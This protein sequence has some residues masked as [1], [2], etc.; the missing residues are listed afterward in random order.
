MINMADE[1]VL[2]DDVQYTR[3]DWR[4]RNKI[5]T[6][7]GL[8]W[9]SIPVEVKGRFDIPIADVTVADQ[10]WGIAHWKTLAHAY[11]KAPAF[12]EVRQWLEP[13]YRTMP[14]RLSEI[15]RTFIEGINAYLGIT[16]PIH[17]STDFITPADKSTRLLSICKS[18]KA[19]SYL[20]GPAARAY[21]DVELFT[22][23]GIAVEWMDYSGYP[24]YPQLYPPFAHD[25][26]ILDLIFSTGKGS[27][28]YMKSFD[29]K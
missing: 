14:L 4:N 27:K 5:K 16:T 2:L 1:F 20:S 19:T 21:L 11:G 25:V 17:W 24:E 13:L 3:R 23:D 28:E 7:Q 6:A 18:L 22:K 10:S 12:E 9:L 26:S 15:N 29:L 8:H